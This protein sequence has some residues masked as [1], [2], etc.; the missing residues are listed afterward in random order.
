MEIQNEKTYDSVFWTSVVRMTR[1]IIPLVNEAFGEHYTDKAEVNLIPGK[2]STEQTDSSFVEREMDAFAKLTESGASKNYHFEVETGTDRSFAIR[3]AEYAAGAAQ[4]NV[5]LTETGAKTVIPYS[6][7][8]FLRARDEIPDKLRMEIEYP[9]GVVSYDA[10]VMKIKNYSVK[11]LID[12]RL[13]LLLPFYG[14]NFDDRFAEMETT[15]IGELKAA[16]DE[17][18]DSLSGLVESGVIDESQK[19]HLL[20]WTKRVLD[21]LTVNYK[22]V[23][24]GVDDLMGGYILH[25]RTDEILDRGRSEG[26][27]EGRTEG[28]NAM[29]EVM[30]RS[31]K[32]P[33]QISEFCGIPLERV[34]EVEKSMLVTA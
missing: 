24:K 7:V 27:A 29:I 31:G 28:R 10:P 20:D 8:I 2:Q 16:L 21:K 23:T 12:K 25:T 17:V 3:I 13:L 6:A 32:T 15:G 19:G 33:E 1:F 9:G 5:T 22:N 14:F 18:D 26:R 34:K 11:E 30:L 4:E